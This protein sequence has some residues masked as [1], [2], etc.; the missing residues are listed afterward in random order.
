VRN[1][2]DLINSNVMVILT[3]FIWTCYY[4]LNLLTIVKPYSFSD[5]FHLSIGFIIPIL[6]VIYLFKLMRNK[7]KKVEMNIE[8]KNPSSGYYFLAFWIL[9]FFLR[10][11]LIETQS[12]LIK[13]ISSVVFVFIVLILIIDNH[14][15]KKLAKKCN[16]MERG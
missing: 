10:Y 1:E 2:K 6:F 7:E 13:V 3:F 9:L 12:L 11:N 15:R 8:S 16:S 14:K 4:L 5:N